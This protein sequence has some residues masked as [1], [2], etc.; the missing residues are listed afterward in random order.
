M[1]RT[2]KQKIDYD[3]VVRSVNLDKVTYAQKF[4]LWDRLR[5]NP[6]QEDMTL[7]K[8][9]SLF[10]Y[11][12]FLD[13]EENP[14]K[15]TDYQDAI[16]NCHHDFK[17]DNPNRIVIYR[18]SNQS[19]KC[20]YEGERLVNKYGLPIRMKDIQIG[21]IVLS[22]KEGKLVHGVVT[23]KSDRLVK[24]GYLIK[25]K[26]GK[27]LV[28]SADHRF[29]T[30]NGWYSINT[31]LSKH[32]YKSA[33]KI[34]FSE[35]RSMVK[36]PLR[37]YPGKERQLCD[38]DIKLLAY[39]TTDGYI[40]NDS[41]SMKFTNTSQLLLDEFESCA[42]EYGV[43][44]KKYPK[45][46]G[47][48]YL[49]TYSYSKQN[50]IKK[51]CLDEG[52]WIKKKER[53][54]P[55]SVLSGTEEEIALFINRIFACDGTLFK[56]MSAGQQRCRLVFYSPSLTYAKD[57]REVLLKLGIHTSLV[58]E[59]PHGNATQDGYR[60]NVQSKRDILL[61]FKKIGLIYSKEV[62]SK[63]CI[64]IATAQPDAFN[65]KKEYR[66]GD[67]FWDFITSIEPV[68]EKPFYDITVESE[69]N[70]LCEG[71][72][73]HNSRLLS[74]LAIYHAWFGKNVNIV[75]VSNNITASQ[76]LLSTIRHTLNNS[77]FADTW[78]ESVG[79]T[80]NTTHL[81][82]VK[83]K[84]KIVNRI[85]C[86]PSGEGLLGYPVHYLYLDEFD[87]Y[88]D[89]KKFFWKV[90]L[91]RTNR[92]KGQ[93]IGFSNP[94][95]D[96]SRQSSILW[97]L[98]HSDLVKRKFH[99][100]FLDAPWNTRQEYDLI[101]KSSPS[102]IFASTHD[103]EFPPDAGGFFSFKEIQD[104]M[105]RDWKNQLPVVDRP[106]YIGLDLAKVKDHTVL[107]LGVLQEN[108]EDSKLSDLDIRYMIRFPTKTDYDVVVNKLKEIIDFY[109]DNFYGV[110]RIGFDATGVG[111][112][113]EDMLKMKGILAT[114]VIFS[115][116]HK[117]KMFANFKVLAE[118]R[119]IKIVHDDQCEKELSNLVMA[120]TATGKL[121]VR[122]E[123][124]SDFDDFCDAI[125]ALIDVSV[126]PSK[127]PVTAKFVD[128]AETEDK[129]ESDDSV[130]E[131][132][133][134]VLLAHLP[135]S[136]GGFMDEDFGGFDE[137]W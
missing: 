51:L 124:E 10:A 50:P 92:T 2:L 31:G 52:V 70:F 36:V 4:E 130:K 20:L 107:V 86:R 66:D 64:D 137:E 5:K 65:Y 102:Y 91:P 117:S 104:I 89:G 71:I 105:Q 32:D 121:Q 11:E 26:S 15:L 42:N 60:V 120:R 94:N 127:V 59:K 73:T 83:D 41:Q 79:E 49:A 43:T 111:K 96:R 125:V 110:G 14:F 115:L 74:I 7:L 23:A 24:E 47:F 88:E 39:L 114:G 37:L 61:F 106:V 16:A 68:G 54:L 27:Q 62:Q 33:R 76:Y 133:K 17:P 13:D 22:H 82:F 46:N 93:I 99:F 122:H 119:R 40:G 8:D 57:I 30:P 35:L 44:C 6:S 75:M 132:E 126:T 58:V 97:E 123:S 80:A 1:L 9:V 128:Y 118:Q 81:T 69:H 38:R 77:A 56:Y 25:T 55:K 67:F 98:W 84:G 129:P 85:I 136:V 72:V 19:G 18:A 3:S 103:G 63:E 95:P 78:R 53:G 87:F 100:T 116:E 48:D 29:L 90:A 109:K 131:Y 108:K 113:I 28:C 135:R 12:Y 101:K 45:N 21:E 34:P 112:G 134:N